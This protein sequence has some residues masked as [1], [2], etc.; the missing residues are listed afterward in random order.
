MIILEEAQRVVDQAKQAVSEAQ[1]AVNVAL[2]QLRKATAS[3]RVKREKGEAK[4]KRKRENEPL[5]EEIEKRFTNV[6]QVYNGKVGKCCCG[7]SGTHTYKVGAND[8][9]DEDDKTVQR[10][11]NKIRRSANQGYSLETGENYV[12]IEVGTRLYLAYDK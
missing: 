8:G 1:N 4:A 6:K 5:E 11:I 7:C 9:R 2:E 3:D 10:I 12:G